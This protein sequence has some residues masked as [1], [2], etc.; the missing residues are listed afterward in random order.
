MR[1]PAVPVE[2]VAEIVWGVL[3]VGYLLSAGRPEFLRWPVLSVFGLSAGAALL[4]LYLRR[5]GWRWVL[6]YDAAVWSLLLSAMVAVTG[7]RG[8]QVWPAYVLMSL[9][10]PSL[11]RPL[12]HY[13]L[14][15]L[16]SL[17]YLGIYLLVNPGGA[18][19]LPGL[20]ALRI[21]LF[22]LVTY[23][24]D[25]SM[26][27]ERSA[28]EQAVR[29]SRERVSELVSARDAER[30]EIAH[31][32]HDWLGTGLV[33][34]MRKL[35]LAQRAP[36]A[37]AVRA[38]GAEA[39]DSLRRAHEELRRV[40][41]RLHP[42][43]LEQMGLTAA[44][45]AYLQAW[46]EE[47]GVATAFRGDT[48][49]EP[50]PDV[51]L[52]VYRMLQEGLNNVAKHA[53]ARGVQVGLTLRADRLTLTVA[54]D[55]AGFDPNRRLGPSG[56]EGPPGLGEGQGR[57]R[58]LAGMRERAGAFGGSLGIQSRPGHGATIT[59]DIPLHRGEPS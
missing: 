26:A 10:A 48:A 11:G 22:F 23:V 13:G 1:K 56:G 30:R 5:T 3:L 53:G 44:L 45:Q 15:A 55:G 8:S 27:R 7:G 24:V 35:E 12:L 2:N 49:P 16:N 18:P 6:A 40:M 57:G 58:G 33:A 14:M 52:A 20:L 17:F 37:E 34:P 43:L 29:A 31:D 28:L 9:T 19:L 54:D 38:R 4:E 50:S 42:H 47:H 32:L 39:L 46:G 21:G 36:D 25:L 41:E 59:A 51:A